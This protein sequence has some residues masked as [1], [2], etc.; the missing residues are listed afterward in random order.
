MPEARNSAG[1][2][3]PAA[4]AT[5]PIAVIADRA[6]REPAGRLVRTSPSRNDAHQPRSARCVNTMTTTER[7]IA[8]YARPPLTGPCTAA[9]YRSSVTAPLLRPELGQFSAHLSVLAGARRGTSALPCTD[10]RTYRWT[11]SKR[12][13]GLATAGQP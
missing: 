5:R 10:S 3:I 11:G 2:P 1:P 9:G 13:V 6:P 12:P 7:E 4:S 8:D